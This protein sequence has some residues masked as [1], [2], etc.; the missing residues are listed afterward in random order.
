MT[1]KEKK[2]DKF[3]KKRKNKMERNYS[4]KEGI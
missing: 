2:H 3:V 1:E 4:K